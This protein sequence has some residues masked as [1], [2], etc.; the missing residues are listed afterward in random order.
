MRRHIGPDAARGPAS[1]LVQRPL[2]HTGR[3]TAL[4]FLGELKRAFEISDDRFAG[5]GR[6]HGQ[7]PSQLFKTKAPTVTGSQGLSASKIL[8]PGRGACFEEMLL[9]NR[10]AS[11]DSALP[12]TRSVCNLW[13]FLLRRQTLIAFLGDEAVKSVICIQLRV[14]Q[15]L[16][17]EQ[18]RR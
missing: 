11:N 14:S 1:R 4:D 8:L 15:E 17:D 16:S 10:S 2:Y 9:E 12:S 5:L 6:I 7:S 3:G 18:R 13:V